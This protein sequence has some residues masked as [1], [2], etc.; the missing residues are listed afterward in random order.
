M[1][2]VLG[3][4]QINICRKVLFYRSIFLDDDIMQC[5][6]ESYLSTWRTFNLMYC[7]TLPAS[8]SASLAEHDLSH[9]RWSS[10]TEAAFHSNCT[11]EPEYVNLK[12]PKNRFQGIDSVRLKIDAWAP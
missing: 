3:L 4:R 12:E 6:F 1:F 11:T 8:E 7:T 5:L 2:G 10:Y 9:V